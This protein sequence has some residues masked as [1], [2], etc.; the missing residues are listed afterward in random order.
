MGLGG[1][2]GMA[3]MSVGGVRITTSQ[4]VIAVDSDEE[5]ESTS[6]AAAR[7]VSRR[8]A[9]T[10]EHQQQ[11][12]TNPA[13]AATRVS[14]RA[15]GGGGGAVVAV[16][17][18]EE[19]FPGRDAE[20][21]GESPAFRRMR[22][23]QKTGLTESSSSSSEEE[24]TPVPV[25]VPSMPVPTPART[26]PS[27]IIRAT[28][29]LGKLLG[30]GAPGKGDV[31]RPRKRSVTLG[32]APASAAGEAGDA[33]VSSASPTASGGDGSGSVSPRSNN[34]TKVSKFF[35]TVISQDTA[36]A[37]QSK[38]KTI[39]RP[40]L[41]GF[42]NNEE[43]VGGSLRASGSASGENT[44]STSRVGASAAPAG[45][46]ASDTL[47]AVVSPQPLAAVPA[48]RL[49]RSSSVGSFD[50]PSWTRER[51]PRSQGATR[52]SPRPAGGSDTPQVRSGRLSLTMWRPS[53]VVGKDKFWFEVAVD[54]VSVYKS[55]PLHNKKP[56]WTCNVCCDAS[57]D[58]LIIIRLFKGTKEADKC[59]LRLAGLLQGSE[60]VASLEFPGGERQQVT[61]LALDFG[62]P[63]GGGGA[64]SSPEKCVALDA[65]NVLDVVV[66]ALHDLR[67]VS[68]GSLVMQ[69][70]YT[71]QVMR[72][73]KLWTEP[74]SA[75]IQ[76]VGMD[77]TFRLCASNAELV[78]LLV[79][80]D[81]FPGEVLCGARVSLL[82]ATQ[83]APVLLPLRDKGGATRAFCQ[84]RLSMSSPLRGML[85]PSLGPPLMG[86]PLRLEWGDLVLFNLKSLSAQ[87]VSAATA[88]SWDHCGIVYEEDGKYFLLE[89]VSN[90]VQGNCL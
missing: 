53:G 59:H 54:Y 18:R 29:K 63:G 27:D 33:V 16:L 24:E 43:A 47:R 62:E 37:L 35:G 30:G 28:P 82:R 87:V 56:E 71:E 12:Q 2:V 46:R 1:L 6:S 20:S 5:E 65:P 26:A 8:S 49:R 11:E 78:L 69:A 21:S 84:L 70:S 10:E 72:S 66:S 31:G 25:P 22:K 9:R 15:A 51:S 86:V 3:N 60:R 88:S 57:L 73:G 89:A 13:A 41:S 75:R 76:D 48:T 67:L 40:A 17:K 74:E 80:G 36:S 32:E 64:V 55:P 79:G 7:E 19:S 42:G 14:P 23:P 85:G 52:V 83:W 4:R 50:S 34:M 44:R 58:S 90:G 61:L 38:A 39:R 77:C 45:E 68:K 81:S